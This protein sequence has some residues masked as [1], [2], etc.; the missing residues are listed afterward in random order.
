MRFPYIVVADTRIVQ[1]NVKVYQI[2]AFGWCLGAIKVAFL[3]KLLYN[4][5]GYN[6]FSSVIESDNS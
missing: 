5:L 4:S 6:L 3:F 1:R 2:K